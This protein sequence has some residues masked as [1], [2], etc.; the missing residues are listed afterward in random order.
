MPIMPRLRLVFDMRRV[1]SDTTR[2]LLRC[3]VDRPIVDKLVRPGLLRENLGDGGR[4][5]RLPVVDVPNGAN[6][7][8]RFCAREGLGVPA[9]RAYE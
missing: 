1:D 4:E 9:S 7:H 6:V 8:V 2:P 5:G 3:L